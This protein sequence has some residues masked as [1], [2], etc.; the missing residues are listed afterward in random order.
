MLP[1]LVLNLLHRNA[2]DKN[3]RSVSTEVGGMVSSI[4]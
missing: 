4:W 1:S 2:E 3:T